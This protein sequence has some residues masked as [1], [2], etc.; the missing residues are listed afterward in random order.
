MTVAV[1]LTD[2][3][4]AWQQA[5]VLDIPEWQLTSGDSLFLYGPSGSGKSTLLNLLCGVLTPQSGQVKIL[6]TAINQLSPGKR[7]RFRARHIGMVFQQFNLLPYLS[8]KDNIA[9]AASF[10][11]GRQLDADWRHTLIERL[12]LTDDI[13]Q[14]KASDLSVGQQQRVAVVRALLNKPE[15]II[16]DEPTSALD[17]DLRDHFIELLLSSA[18]QSNATVIFVSHDK[19]LARHFDHHQNLAEINQ[20]EGR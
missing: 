3:R 6:G 11:G 15:L 19:D 20:V 14:R 17:S 16:A 7:D 12:E 1:K 2:V 4:F 18:E 5:P 9:L 13:L 8:V 10:S